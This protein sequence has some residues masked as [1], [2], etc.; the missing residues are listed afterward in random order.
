MLQVKRSASFLSMALATLFLVALLVSTAA[1]ETKT[2]KD[3]VTFDVPSGLTANEVSQA[4]ATVATLMNPSAPMS[5]YTVT[6][7]EDLPGELK[8]MSKEEATTAFSA[9]GSDFEL[10]EYKEM[11]FAGKDAVLIEYKA[12]VQGMNIQT[13]Q[14]MAISGQDMV[15]VTSSCMD[16]SQLA[17]VK[18]TAEKLEASVKIK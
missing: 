17:D 4:N 6:L 7:T 10:I 2:L 11:K 8:L 18:K 16:Q 1:A 9:T 12:N 5:V 13:R 15:M 14:I 3:K